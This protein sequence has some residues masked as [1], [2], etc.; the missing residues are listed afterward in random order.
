[1]LRVDIVNIEKDEQKLDGGICEY[2]YEVS[3][4]NLKVKTLVGIHEGK[5][6][7]DRS[8]GANELLRAV[9]NDIEVKR[10]NFFDEIKASRGKE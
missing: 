10:N 7:H 9:A 8:K 4:T 5:I 1:M 2:E 6:Y 3:V